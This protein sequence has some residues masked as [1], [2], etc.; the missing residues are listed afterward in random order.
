MLR[1]KRYVN[2]GTMSSTEAKNMLFDVL[3]HRE[4]SSL[5][6][7]SSG[8]EIEYNE[9]NQIVKILINFQNKK[10]IKKTFKALTQNKI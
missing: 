2:P 3:S 6:D 5:D 7:N 4:E 10:L 9:S 8:S 1:R